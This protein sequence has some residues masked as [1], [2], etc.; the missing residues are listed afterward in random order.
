[1]QTTSAADEN[2]SEGPFLLEEQTC[3]NGKSQYAQLESTTPILS[4]EEGQKFEPRLTRKKN[5]A[6]RWWWWWWWWQWR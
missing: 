5:N 6:S 1:M 4:Q 2:L 3:S